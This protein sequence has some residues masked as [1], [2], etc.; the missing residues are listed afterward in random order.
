M[1]S[2]PIQYHDDEARRMTEDFISSNA[3][4][5]DKTSAEVAADCSGQTAVKKN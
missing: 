4:S 2:P 1:K 3:K 5:T